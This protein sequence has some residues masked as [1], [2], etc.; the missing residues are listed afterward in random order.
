MPIENK[1]QLPTK[2][3]PLLLYYGVALS[4]IV[5]RKGPVRSD[6]RTLSTHPVQPRNRIADAAAVIIFFRPSAAST[7]KL[8]FGLKHR[9]SS[10]SSRRPFRYTVVRFI[11]INHAHTREPHSRTA[12]PSVCLPSHRRNVPVRGWRN[13]VN[14]ILKTLFE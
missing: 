2:F 13:D 12:A 5:P 1:K 6:C 14:D 11:I 7:R 10:S 8:N 4:V 3:E 9:L